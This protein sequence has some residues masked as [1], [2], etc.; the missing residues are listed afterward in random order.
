MKSS[1]DNAPGGS[2]ESANFHFVGQIGTLPE[3]DERKEDFMCYMERLEQFFLANNISEGR[4]VPCF[5]SAVGSTTYQTLRNL[6]SPDLPSAKYYEELKTLLMRHFKPKPSVIA[7]RCKFNNCYQRNNQGMNEFI[8]EIKKLSEYC[9]FD[10]FLNDALR[11]RLVCG[12]HERFK[13]IQLKLLTEE[14]LDFKKACET[15][16][17]MEMAR[18]ETHEM[19]KDSPSARQGQRG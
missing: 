5:L 7:E 1:E 16:L 9:E 4:R 19:Q 8:V 2:A 10:T 12:L 11:D 13:Q 17:N 15:A 14:N 3:F 6:A 18:K